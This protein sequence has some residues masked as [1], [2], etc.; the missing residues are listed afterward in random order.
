MHDDTTGYHRETRKMTEFRSRVWLLRSLDQG[1]EELRR[2]VRWKSFVLDAISVKYPASSSQQRACTR[3]VVF[4]IA[5][6]LPERN[7]DW[8]QPLNLSRAIPSTRFQGRQKKLVT[9]GA[10]RRKVYSLGRDISDGGVSFRVVAENT[11]TYY[12]KCN[13]RLHGNLYSRRESGQAG[14]SL[15]SY[16]LIYRSPRRTG[17]VCSYAI[18]QSASTIY[19]AVL[20]SSYAVPAT[21]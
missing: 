13:L 5:A 19:P 3:V 15:F 4:E 17:D 20:L 8:K 18:L 14:R 9:R 21:N 11:Q 10:N 1:A 6:W 16:S 12:S 7:R 2:Y